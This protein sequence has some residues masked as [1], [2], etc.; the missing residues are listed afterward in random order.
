M[1]RYL[2][3]LW[4]LV[5]APACSSAP[6]VLGLPMDCRPGA[7][8]W[9]A[10]LVD[11]DPG[12]ASQDYACGTLTYN[13][14]NGVDFAVRDLAAMTAGM[15][16]KAA[17]AGRVRAVRDNEPDTSVKERGKDAVKGRE[18]GNG[19]VIDHDEGWQT[20]Y[21]HLRRGSISVRAGQRVSAGDMLGL[22][23]LSGLTEYPHLHFTLRQNG[24]TVD[25]FLGLGSKCGSA[26][27]ALWQAEALA[28]LSY[29]PGVIYNYGA[30]D[31]LPEA[32]AVRRGEYGSRALPAD[33]PAL[34]IWVDIFAIEEDGEIVLELT[35]PDGKPF[36][37]QSIRA[38]KRLA[39]TFRAVGRKRGL[40]PWPTGVYHARITVNSPRRG[41]VSSVG[42]ELTVH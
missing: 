38:E 6:P 28:Q 36:L 14:H 5:F 15:A 39:R 8:C 1:F 11:L 31:R 37:R 27:K 26:T 17:A 19:V 32:D 3:T 25:P 40:T 21:C 33:S 4:I 24:A 29:L 12:P 41:P 35:G 7:D 2:L 16:V 10:N 23:G 18:C 42:F 34:V 20:Q 30:A 9:I 22:V 13:D